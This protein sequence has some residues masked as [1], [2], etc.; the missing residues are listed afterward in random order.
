[1]LKGRRVPEA[2]APS[3]V[4]ALHTSIME[5][6]RRC[7]RPLA[8]HDANALTAELYET[9]VQLG[10]APATSL[11]DISI[12]LAVLCRRLREHLHPEQRGELASYLLAASILED[13]GIW[14]GGTDVAMADE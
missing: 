10:N 11:V 13:C 9:T 7:S 12:K 3:L 2:L 1:M 6:H 4:Q 8:D 5:M 14:L